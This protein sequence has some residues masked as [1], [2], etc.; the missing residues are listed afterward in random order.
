[1]SSNTTG[2][3]QLY[4]TYNV[5]SWRNSLLWTLV[6]LEFREPGKPSAKQSLEWWENHNLELSAVFATATS[7][8]AK[9]SSNS[10]AI[11]HICFM[12]NAMT[13]LSST[14]KRKAL[15]YYAQCVEHQLIKRKL[16]RRSW[17]QKSN[18]WMTHSLWVTRFRT[19]LSL[20]HHKAVLLN[21]LILP[22]IPIK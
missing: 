15:G 3:C 14:T 12:N 16:S 8:Q 1:M 22:L 13:C 11:Q 21:P 4:E 6:R 17:R 9:R 5:R 20:C 2:I 19:K 7:H 18:Q 10:P